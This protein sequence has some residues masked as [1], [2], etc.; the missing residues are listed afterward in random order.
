MDHKLNR[1]TLAKTAGALAGGTALRRIT[2]TVAQEATPQAGF[3]V[4]ELPE[5]YQIEKVVEGLSFPTGLTWDDQGQMYVAEA[6]GAFLELDA[7]SRILQIQNGQATEVVNLTQSVGTIA[8]VVGLFWHNGA[9]YF[10]HRDPDDRTGAVSRVTADG[11][12]TQL[13]SG[14]VDNQSEHQINDIRMGPDGRMYVASGPAGNAAVMG[15][16]NAP[17][18]MKSPDVHTVPCADIVL[19]GQNYVTPDF[20]SDDPSDTVMT[21]AYVP[22][23][24]ET[25]PGQV[26][27]GTTKCGGAILVFDPESDNPEETLAVHA[28][29]LR[30][31]IGLVWDAD[32][33]MYA[34]VNGYDIRGSRPVQDEFDPTYRIEEGVWYGWPDFSAALEPL[35]DPKFG[36]PDS[37]QPPVVIDGKPAKMEAPGFLIDHEASGLQVADQSLI[38]GLHD[39][40]SSPSMLDVAPQSWNEFA[41]QLFIAEWGDLAPP[42]NPLRDKPTGYR[43]VRLDPQSGEVVPFAQNAMPGAASQQ[44]AMGQGLERPFDVKFG[45]D[46]AMYIVDYG[47]ARINPASEGPPYEFPP[48]TGVIWKVTPA[49]ASSTTPAS[50]A[51]ESEALEEIL[52]PEPTE[53]GT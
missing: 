13:F 14:I 48:A 26:I 6:G 17:F 23:G 11:Q 33:V 46:G 5:G 36:V 42:T 15:L 25:M 12:V 22:F 19:T 4:V 47:V 51:E 52:T 31:V 3:P 41:G 40:N 45:P 8:S 1:R 30:N 27:E 10:T 49:N 16:D 39:W 7:P 21:G 44:M 18:I 43:V 24:T 53:E 37:L 50:A 28:W 34:A 2:P 35:T 32:G 29:G 38:A 9:F 20:R